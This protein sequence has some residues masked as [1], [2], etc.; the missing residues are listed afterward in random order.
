MQS[1]PT[2]IPARYFSVAYTLLIIISVQSC[3]VCS[4]PI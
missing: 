3:V 4:Q 2:E 1:N